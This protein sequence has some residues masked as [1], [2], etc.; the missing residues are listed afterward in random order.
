VTNDN[1]DNI[2]N[3]NDNNNNDDSDDNNDDTDR[4]CSPMTELR[5]NPCSDTYCGKA[6]QAS[7]GEQN[8]SP[9]SPKC[10]QI[11]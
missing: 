2:D 9:R 1:K 10:Q 11:S 3:D 5:R 6:Q 8:R 4:C 7:I